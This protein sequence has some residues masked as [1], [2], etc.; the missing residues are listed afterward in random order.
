MTRSSY[1]LYH[2]AQEHS[3]DEEGGIY[4]TNSTSCSWLSCHDKLM[5]QSGAAQKIISAYGSR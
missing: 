5:Q 1:I 4:K 3:E 2:L